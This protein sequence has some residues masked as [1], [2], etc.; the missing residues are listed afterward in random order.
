MS[1]ESVNVLT[2]TGFIEIAKGSHIK[3]EYN[4]EKRH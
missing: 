4:K 1:V 2:L 3:Y